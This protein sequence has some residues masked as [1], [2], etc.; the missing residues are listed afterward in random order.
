MIP[1]SATDSAKYI[2][3]PLIDVQ[4]QL[5]DPDSQPT[6]DSLNARDVLV[7][8]FSKTEGEAYV[9]NGRPCG[10]SPLY[11][12][13]GNEEDAGFWYDEIGAKIQRP[14]EVDTQAQE[15]DMDTL[16]T[17]RPRYLTVHSAFL[18]IS[19]HRSEP[20]R[21][22][23]DQTE[24]STDGQPMDLIRT[25]SEANN[26]LTRTIEADGPP[27][28]HAQTTE[29]SNQPESDY[30]TRD[31]V[32]TA[33]ETIDVR[34]HELHDAPFGPEVEEGT[35]ADSVHIT[36]KQQSAF[37]ELKD[38]HDLRITESPSARYPR[39]SRDPVSE[40]VHRRSG[41]EAEATPSD[42]TSVPRSGKLSRTMRVED[43]E[44][45]F[46]LPLTPAMLSSARANRKRGDSTKA[47]PKVD[48]NNRKTAS[49]SKLAAGTKRKSL[50]QQTTASNKKARHTASLS[51]S[52][53]SSNDH[54]QN[55]KTTPE[56]SVFDV[57]SSSPEASKPR[58][59]PLRIGNAPKK[60]AKSGEPSRDVKRLKEQ[61]MTS[62]EATTASS[63][64]KVQS[65]K[66]TL[67]K[68]GPSQHQ[69]TLNSQKLPED[70]SG[71]TQ[72]HEEG[73]NYI[74]SQQSGAKAKSKAAPEKDK[75]VST[76][77]Q[78][79]GVKRKAQR[80][81]PRQDIATGL[82]RQ[83]RASTRRTK[84]M[85]PRSKLTLN[86][87][88]DSSARKES[89]P[90]EM[91]SEAQPGEHL[92]P[93]DNQ[94]TLLA[95]ASANPV[96]TSER[97]EA[98]VSTDHP[99][100][101]RIDETQ[102]TLQPTRDV[103]QQT[104]VQSITALYNA[105]GIDSGERAA[106]GA[107]PAGASVDSNQTKIRPVET[108]PQVHSNVEATLNIDDDR[109]DQQSSREA[110]NFV[111]AMDVIAPDTAGNESFDDDLFE[112]G[113]AVLQ[114]FDFTAD[115]VIYKDGQL[116]SAPTGSAAAIGGRGKEGGHKGL[117]EA[118]GSEPAPQS[119]QQGI[120]V[121]A[122]EGGN[123][124]SAA[125]AVDKTE[126]HGKKSILQTDHHSHSPKASTAESLVASGAHCHLAKKLETALS[127]V[128]HPQD[129][130]EGK[131]D[132]HTEELATHPWTNNTQVQNSKTPQL[133]AGKQVAVQGLVH[134]PL[135]DRH[136]Q[137]SI[138]GP[139]SIHKNPKSGSQSDPLV[140]SEGSSSDH[141]FED[142]ATDPGSRA[143]TPFR[144]HQRSY[145]ERSVKPALQN[146]EQI[147]VTTT[148]ASDTSPEARRVLP[149]KGLSV[150]AMTRNP[151][152]RIQTPAKDVETNVSAAVS[153][154]S[155][156]NKD[157]NRL[158]RIVGFSGKGPRNQGVASVTA[159][160]AAQARMEPKRVSE[161]NKEQPK[162]KR[163]FGALSL[164]VADRT[165]AQTKPYRDSKRVRIEVLDDEL[166]K[167]AP[168][169]LR[170]PVTR[171]PGSVKDKVLF[172]H[173]SW[174]ADDAGPKKSSQSSR[175]DATGSPLPLRRTRHA[176]FPRNEQRRLDDYLS[177]S[178]NVDPGMMD[179]EFT[180]VNQ[181][182]DQAPEPELPVIAV[183]GHPHKR[184]LA[185]IPSSNSKHGPS[186][187][188]APSAMLTA[189]QAH[190][191]HESGRLVNLETDAVLE[192]SKPQDPF[193][194]KGQEQPD[195]FLNLLRRATKADAMRKHAYEKEQKSRIQGPSQ[196]SG[197]IGDG[198]SAPE[199]EDPDQTLVEDRRSRRRRR[200]YSTLSKT[201]DSANPDD[202]GS[203][204]SENRE[205][206]E[207][208]VR[209]WRD[210]LDPRHQDILAI[211]YEVSHVSRPI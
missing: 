129:P 96:E 186:S 121:Q 14:D 203:Q 174:F 189:F 162:R 94:T 80:T 4:L 11:I 188:T 163:E 175:V 74:P 77:K 55:D 33:E 201:S 2:D 63:R 87:E 61:A 166:Q 91:V 161:G 16:E 17:L 85:A 22:Q 75:K 36:R 131:G 19:D 146:P 41:S 111:D 21:A 10:P 112:D 54:L 81:Q 192:P 147:L 52:S 171:S 78:N 50:A 115:H 127:D 135:G 128:L 153:T 133:G 150:D 185:R 125:S 46:V 119:A 28:D 120:T 152:Q 101:Q 59:R 160:A 45:P 148:R 124:E 79:T 3:I 20:G 177:D 37:E 118:Q 12:F 172:E 92:V 200:R 158:P 190:E 13:F 193:T 137:G 145:N 206:H 5:G 60:D 141:E 98:E 90:P 65:T 194:T 117:E 30:G 123:I 89:E 107:A 76:A 211:L 136:L 8:T 64:R 209:A 25:A 48:G 126:D 114:A 149:S 170:A 40:L 122:N 34:Q 27:H 82:Q 169:S 165:P 134:P 156:R 143:A 195:G 53:R 15:E 24:E 32:S 72:S 9:I 57:P 132:I 140:V 68:E 144:H 205:A 164:D 155:G 151:R 113:Q 71:D 159:H 86:E 197:Q 106:A 69:S 180:L 199:D 51:F 167:P 95:T 70:D 49:D 44:Q 35:H 207:A 66:N 157:P 18:D 191:V 182:S 31:I 116:A 173:S 88:G 109:E 58:S 93:H 168:A 43:G 29:E 83:T 183:S 198:R 187:P 142:A 176:F 110:T 6:Q 7:L 130:F 196:A 208:A 62:D 108:A 73:S 42:A 26:L 181:D 38:N 67:R 56:A 105:G 97:I 23:M 138:K 84:N 210:A 1:T 102:A 202:E 178:E 99:V 100:S 179:D 104:S 154:N 39:S 184:E 139:A 47:A 204:S 103:Q